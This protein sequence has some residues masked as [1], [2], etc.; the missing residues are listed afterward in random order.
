MWQMLLGQ[1]LSALVAGVVA[2][3][4]VAAQL[5]HEQHERGRVGREGLELG[6]LAIPVADVIGLGVH[7]QRADPDV[8]CCS[9]HLKHA[10]TQ[11]RSSE[12]CV[13]MPD[14]D[15]QATEH[16]NLG[17]DGR[18]RLGGRGPALP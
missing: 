10:A 1:A 6:L 11:Q 16:H 4:D 8:L 2:V 18:G 3:L 15:G 17:W 9:H 5:L 13:L 12:A 7:E 14:V